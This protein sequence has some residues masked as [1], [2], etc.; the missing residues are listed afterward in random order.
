MRRKIY[1][2]LLAWK[3]AGATK[4]LMVIG[5]RQVGKTYT[6]EEFAQAEY[7]EFVQFN[8]T[9]QKDIVRLF[10]SDINTVD[11]VKQLQYIIGRPIDYE[12][13]LLFFD[14]IQE[15]E[16]LI[17]ALKYFAE[18]PINYNIIC[19]GS[20]LGVKIKRFKRSFPVGKVKMLH[21]HPM[22]FE[23]YLDAFDDSGLT[24]FI[25]E[26]LQGSKQMSEPLH[27]KC[28]DYFRR[29]L[30][31]GGMPEAVANLLS[32]DNE[33]LR[34]DRSIHQDIYESYLADMTK[35]VKNPQESAKIEAVYRMM[36]TQ[37]GNSSRKFQYSKVRK[38]AKGR[39]Y[40]SAISWLT[41][42]EMVLQCLAISDAQ[43]P[44]KGFLDDGVFKLFFNDPGILGNLVDVRYP[45][46]ML[47]KIS[48][49]KGILTEN[50][51]AAQLVSTDVPLHY[52]RIESKYEVDF[53]IQTGDGIIPIEAKAGTNKV[54]ASLRAYQNTY[55]PSWVIRLSARNYGFVN[56]VRTIPLYAAFA[57]KELTQ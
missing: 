29:Y 10:D 2:Q 33:V 36:P 54:S 7:P 6:I 15:S 24:T 28:L 12:H 53:L 25:R 3:A 52:W 48:S 11:K 50:Y 56:Q 8:L 32:V 9:H 47:N 35:Y 44:L 19:A 57:I 21:M 41:A 46:I 55:N 4:P 38:G 49:Y 31:V 27:D 13:T 18:S 26:C 43:M 1:H 34:F 22:D 16:G 37:L 51:V 40:D 20:L 30:C 14:E 17:E 5:A 39:D 42:S 45:D 23:E